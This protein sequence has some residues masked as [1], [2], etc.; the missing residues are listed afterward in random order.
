MRAAGSVHIRPARSIS[1]HSAPRVSADRAA[2]STRNSNASFTAGRAPDLRTASTAAPTSRW[3]SARMCRTRSRWRPS[4][5]PMRP[6]G[7]SGR[8]SI[9]TAQSITVWMRWRSRR[10]VGGWRCQTSRSVSITSAVVRS[11]TGVSPMRGR[12]HRAMNDFQSRAYFRLR[13]PGRSCAQTRSAA[14]AKV[15]PLVRCFSL[16]GS[17]PRRASFRLAKASARASSSDTS[18]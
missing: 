13:Q 5:S 12:A 17:P 7:L 1:A 10:A 2:V 15:I 9:A 4:T 11:T 18:G 14:A 8:C 3:G 6:H 16:V